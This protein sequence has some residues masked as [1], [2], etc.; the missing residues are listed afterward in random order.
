MLGWLVKRDLS[1]MNLNMMYLAFLFARFLRLR[2][3]QPP[4]LLQVHGIPHLVCIYLLISPNIHLID[5]YKRPS[6]SPNPGHQP[7]SP[8][9][10]LLFPHPFNSSPHTPYFDFPRRKDFYNL[11]GTI[12]HT[13]THTLYLNQQNFGLI[14]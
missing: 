11:R 2:S 4:L 12:I 13:N 5:F 8:P 14:D 3:L 10:L 6:P 1:P 7:H 9:P